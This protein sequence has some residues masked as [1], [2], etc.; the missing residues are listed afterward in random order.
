[1]QLPYAYYKFGHTLFLNQQFADQLIYADPQITVTCIAIIYQNWTHYAFC[2]ATC[3]FSLSFEAL[4][5][6]RDSPVGTAL[7]NG[8]DDRGSRVRFPAG[9]WEFFSSPQRPE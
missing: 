2:F 5:K 8:T 3:S 1:L 4:K 7:G 6:I 9:G